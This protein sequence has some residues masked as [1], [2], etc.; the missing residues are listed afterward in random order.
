MKVIIAVDE[1]AYGKKIIE[2]IAH[3][4]WQPDTA[5][6]IISVVEPVSW[7]EVENE[8]WAGLSKSMFE[9]RKKNATDLCLELKKILETQH[10]DCTVH[11]DVREGNP[12]KEILGAAIDWMA[13]KILIGAHGHDLCDRFVWGGVSRAV[14]TAAPC[15]V[16][17]VRPYTRRSKE[18]HCAKEQKNEATV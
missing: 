7:D 11:V 1:S 3:R 18:E 5:F 6:R 16:E 9:K 13:D 2:T 4:Q 17:I 15:S 10:P 12:R 8:N 14:A